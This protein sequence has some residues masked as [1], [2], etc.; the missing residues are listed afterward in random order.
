MW[1]SWICSTTNWRSC[2]QCLLNVGMMVGEEG[3]TK[4]IAKGREVEDIQTK[5]ECQS[6]S[7]EGFKKLAVVIRTWMYYRKWLT[8]IFTIYKI[9]IHILTITISCLCFFLIGFCA[10]TGRGWLPLALVRHLSPRM[11]R[12]R[13]S[14]SPPSSKW[15]FSGQMWRW[16]APSSV[17]RSKAV[18]SCP[19][20][21]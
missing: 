15:V 12:G 11:T 7:E 19:I 20:A 9:G 14:T 1:Y 10:H 21:L 13:R 5:T 2:I 18:I 16:W 3:V 6:E 4:R 17:Q 8:H